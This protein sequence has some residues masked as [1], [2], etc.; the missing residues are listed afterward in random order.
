MGFLC[1]LMMMLSL[2][3]VIERKKK[4]VGEGRNN[5]SRAEEF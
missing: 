2:E 3:C 4:S 5:L 1:L